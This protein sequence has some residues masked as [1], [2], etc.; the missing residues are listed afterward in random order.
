MTWMYSL[1]WLGALSATAPILF[2]MWRRMPKGERQFS[3][4]MF[5]NPSP[6]RIT[7][8]SRVEH[9]LL[10]LLRAAALA[11]LAF[12]FTRP[13]WR[14]PITDPNDSEGE[15]LVA[16]LVDTSASMRRNGAW[17][18]V[19][20]ELDSRLSKL[21]L[22]TIV[23]LYR[24]DQTVA[25]VADFPEVTGM[26]PEVRRELIRARLKELKPGWDGTDLGQALVR[27][28]ASLQEAQTARSKPA[29]QRIWL[30]SDVQ[31][32]SSVVALQGYEWPDDLPVELI[33][34][35]IQSPSNAGLQ[36][37]ERNPDS[38][39]SQLRVR[40][41]NS[42]DSVKEQFTLKWESPS[43][44]EIAVYVPPG[45]SRVLTPP[46]LP[47]GVSSS[48]L[49][50]T[51]DDDDFDNRVYVAETAPETRLVVFC[52]PEG[53]NDIEGARF[54]LDRLFA[55]SQRFR[56]ELRESRE[57]NV[58]SA[59]AQPS[60]IVM[61]DPEPEQKPLVQKHLENGG[62]ILIASPSAESMQKSLKLCGRDGLT[63]TEATVPKYAMFADINFDHPVF[64][65]FAE[66]QFSDF[67]GI[68]FWKHRK[69]DGLKNADTS[70]PA[71]NAEEDRGSDKVLVRFDDG[72]AAVVEFPVQ[73]G[74]IIVFA[75]GWQPADS[76]F[77]RSS[78]FPMLMFRLLEQSSGIST[79]AGSQ[80]VGTPL[81][82]PTISHLESSATGS[83][84]LP[85]GTELASLPLDQPFGKTAVPGIYTLSVP[86]RTEQVAV[87]LA[88]DESRTSPLSVEQLESYGLKLK[89]REHVVPQQVQ[90]NRQ[91]QLQL[92]E[93]EN[94]QKL[95]QQILVAVIVVLLL[96]TLISGWFGMK[97]SGKVGQEV[98]AS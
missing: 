1:Y 58:A 11:L 79:R 78:K 6:P 38:S 67:T 13:L 80:D 60:L 28:S 8:R 55:A 3:T 41:T 27:I 2:H 45:Q 40:I 9:W 50:L 34:S 64:A 48:S 94:S 23:A 4:L 29:A 76:Q 96:E 20:Q 72:D 57:V 22:K 68:R 97:P 35:Q 86:G 7:S 74:K 14:V 26:E 54:Y 71:G 85:D 66:S 51:G 46:Q 39:D 25:P 31:S 63:V 87:N 77:A 37:V 81:A 32:G 42:S 83:V 75:S 65:P 12:A 56:I 92:A 61:T 43:S 82:W 18:S 36:V 98:A 69:I 24:F 73:R 47:A 88:P 15:Q 17:N 10:M 95:W 70:S 93:M 19:V 89:G 52:G 91:R 16:I 49:I 33:R 44:P 53:S 5:L 90:R 21:P 59:D 62:T 84:R 30:A